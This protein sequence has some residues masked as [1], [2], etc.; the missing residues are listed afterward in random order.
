MMSSSELVQRK[1]SCEN[2]AV[3]FVPIT[4]DLSF[5]QIQPH[6]PN[7]SYSLYFPLRRF[8]NSLVDNPSSKNR[9]KNT[10]HLQHD[11]IMMFLL[12]I[13]QIPPAHHP[14]C[15]STSPFLRIQRQG[16]GLWRYCSHSEM[17]TKERR[18]PPPR[19]G[20]DVYSGDA[21]A[22]PPPFSSST[23]ANPV[24]PKTSVRPQT[25]TSNASTGDSSAISPI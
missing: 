14:F 23:S 5:I 2:E 20:K 18:A 3:Q 15:H 16:S 11:S 21:Y 1:I 13:F 22:S 24:V 9:Q 7:T 6:P 19:K 25:G 4:D 17:K 10:H 12:L 8:S